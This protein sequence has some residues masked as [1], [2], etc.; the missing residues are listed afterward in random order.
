M[1]TLLDNFKSVIAP[2][3]NSQL[4]R[5]GNTCDE[6]RH[7]VIFINH[8]ISSRFD[9]TITKKTVPT[10][11]PFSDAMK[12]LRP[13]EPLT[14]G[15][16]STVANDIV[17]SPVMFG[18]GRGRRLVS[19]SLSQMSMNNN[20]SVPSFSCRQIDPISKLQSK[21]LL[22]KSHRKYIQIVFLFFFL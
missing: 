12:H 5:L 20:S 13:R 7:L 15:L 21:V 10:D 1:D 2:N 8:I 22:L 3:E 9:Q 16:A 19:S 11:N 18:A 14:N 4:Q 17:P 6:L